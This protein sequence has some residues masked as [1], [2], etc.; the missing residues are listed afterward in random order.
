MQ[1][2]INV[3]A[4]ALLYIYIYGAVYINIS[5]VRWFKLLVVEC[6]INVS[7]VLHCAD[8][9]ADL[10]LSILRHCLSANRVSLV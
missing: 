4:G 2:C 7:G 1:Q 3:G 8:D 10:V 5:E 9:V 6:I